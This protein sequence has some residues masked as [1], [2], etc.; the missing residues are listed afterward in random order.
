MPDLQQGRVIIWNWHVFEPQGSAVGGTGARV[1]KA[2][3]AV[4]MTENFVVARKTTSFH[5]K[6]YI[7][8]EVLDARIAKGELRVLEDNT[9][10]NGRRVVKVLGTAYV[11]SDTSLVNRVLRDVTLGKSNILVMNDEAHHAYRIKNASEASGENNEESEEEDNTSA[12][13]RPCGWKGS[14]RSTNFVA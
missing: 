11:E 1:I 10:K 12:R 5:G 14:I 2:G 3:K 7:T 6:K 13:K 8:P 4:P 9:D